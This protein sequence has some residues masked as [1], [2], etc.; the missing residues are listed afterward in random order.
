MLIGGVKVNSY[1]LL[2]SGLAVLALLAA[3]QGADEAVNNEPG[4]I[5]LECADEQVGHG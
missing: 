1:S 5:Q 4:P 2:L 3:G